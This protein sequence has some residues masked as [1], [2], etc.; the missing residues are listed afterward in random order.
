MSLITEQNT[1]PDPS[2]KYGQA[3]DSATGPAGPGFS[4]VQLDS[5]QKVMSGRTNSGRLVQNIASGHNW[6]IKI[7]YNP[8][9]KA[10]FNPVFSFLQL[11][12]N[13]LRPFFVS[14]PQ[15]R[16]P[17]NADFKTFISDSNNAANIKTPLAANAG[18]RYISLINMPTDSTHS[19]EP[20][21]LFTI[22]NS[23][24]LHTKVYQVLRVD[25]VDSYSLS[26]AAVTLNTTRIMHFHPPLTRAIEAN[27]VINFND[28]KFRVVA[29]KDAYG[30]NLNSDNL[31]K[32]SLELE[33]AQP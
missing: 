12:K 29:P 25:T 7:G 30:Y 15:Y 11:R 5:E 3:G 10:E 26:N 17:Q 16:H 9:T 24:S 8:M 4:S 22:N 1:L 32:F 2:N 14:I 18:T 21:D 28:P 23:D 27:C 6:K 31:Y 20:G 13:S 19:P 33:E